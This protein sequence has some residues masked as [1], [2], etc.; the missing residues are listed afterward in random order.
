MY[1]SECGAKVVEGSKFCSSCGERLAGVPISFGGMATETV[2][3]ATKPKAGGKRPLWR[4]IL[5]DRERTA[6]RCVLGIV[7]WVVILLVGMAL[8]HGSSG[9]DYIDM[10][11]SEYLAKYGR[12]G[13]SGAQW[14]IFWIGIL[15]NVAGIAMAYCWLQ[16]LLS[17]IR[18]ANR[19]KSTKAKIVA[20]VICILFYLGFSLFRWFC[21][22]CKPCWSMWDTFIL[23]AVCTAIWRG[24]VG[25]GE[26]HQSRNKASANYD[27]TVETGGYSG[28]VNDIHDKSRFVCWAIGI[29]GALLLIVVCVGVAVKRQSKQQKRIA[30]QAL[31]AFEESDYDRGLRFAT[32]VKDKDS[33]LQYFVG[34]CYANGYGGASSNDVEA[35]RWYRK[36]AELGNTDAQFNLGLMYTKGQGVVQDD[37]EAARWYRKAA[38][39]GNASAQVNLGWVYEN[40]RGV[41]KSDVEAVRWYRKA[42][43]QG[44]AY[45]QRSLGLM[46]ADGRGVLKDDVEAV[47][48]YRKAAEQGDADARNALDLMHKRGYGVEKKD[49]VEAVGDVAEKVSQRPAADEMLKLVVT[50]DGKEVRLAKVKIGD[51]Q[52]LTP[53]FRTGLRKG[54]VVGPFHVTYEKDGKTYAQDFKSISVDWEGVKTFTFPLRSVD[55]SLKTDAN[56]ES[57]SS[58]KGGA[59]R[60]DLDELLWDMENKR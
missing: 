28:E 7:L 57:W 10:R 45:A 59:Q 41:A 1:C 19:G 43:E 60:S 46:Y 39:Q 52:E 55:S 27:P 22:D 32:K 35:V 5:G 33:R 21:N 58:R 51:K 4:K 3:V 40:G 14:L 56:T 17:R 16:A 53:V 44:E 54:D 42:A 2:A 50:V 47:R 15:L 25:V 9:F 23:I 26:K 37:M 49:V 11:T 24:L 6:L 34:V 8:A 30:Q 12:A 29:V 38:E 31:A 36:A 18:P 13:L 48:W 20:S